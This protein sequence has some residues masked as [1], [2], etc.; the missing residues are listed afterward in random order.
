MFYK[1]IPYDSLLRM[2]TEC[3]NELLMRIKEH[4][5]K[6]SGSYLTEQQKQ[7]IEESKNV[8]W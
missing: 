5:N 6:T 8:K 4:T 7:M 1:N 3:L 2:P